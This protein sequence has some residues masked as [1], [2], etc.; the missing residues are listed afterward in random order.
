[1]HSG[2]CASHHG[3]TEVHT[4]GALLQGY[5]SW[6]KMVPR[7]SYLVAVTLSGFISGKCHYRNYCTGVSSEAG[8]VVSSLLS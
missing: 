4:T 3:N 7:G 5:K 2:A 6:G 8:K 1:M